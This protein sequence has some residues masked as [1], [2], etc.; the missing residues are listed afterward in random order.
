MMDMIFAYIAGCARAQST[1]CAW[2]CLCGTPLSEPTGTRMLGKSMRIASAQAVTVWRRGRRDASAHA[3]LHSLPA[4]D[5]QIQI[6][7]G[8]PTVVSSLLIRNS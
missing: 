3:R 4:E 2:L 1:R 5:L 6:H 7:T 8:T